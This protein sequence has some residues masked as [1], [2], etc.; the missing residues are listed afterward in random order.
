MCNRFIQLSLASIPV[1]PLMQQERVRKAISG[2]LLCFTLALLPPVLETESLVVSETVSRFKVSNSFVYPSVPCIKLIF[3]TL[4][5][6]KLVCYLSNFMRS[7][8]YLFDSLRFCFTRLLNGKFYLWNIN[9]EFENNYAVLF[10]KRNI[11]GSKKI[12]TRNR[13]YL[14][15]GTGKP[16][17]EIPTSTLVTFDSVS[18]CLM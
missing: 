6:V 13:Y 12:L 10:V 16:A 1:S 4:L 15:L 17:N 8:K 11:R 18:Y 5:K 3:K 9:K 14:Y 2:I 7:F